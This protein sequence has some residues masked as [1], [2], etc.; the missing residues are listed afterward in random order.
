[1][2]IQILGTGCA[3]CKTLMEN[4]QKAVSEMGIDAEFEKI[5]DIQKIIQY[6]VMTT[7]ALAIDGKVKFAGKV[8]SSDDIKKLLA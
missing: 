8:A 5:E 3:K 2:K 6:G 7:P 4:A 1:M